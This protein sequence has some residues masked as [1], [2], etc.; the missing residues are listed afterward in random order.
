MNV[1]NRTGSNA[2]LLIPQRLDRIDARCFQRG[3]GPNIT[4]TATE[5]PNATGTDAI[6]T[7]V[8]HSA[9]ARYEPGQKNPRS[10]MSGQERSSHAR[11]TMRALPS[12]CRVALFRFRRVINF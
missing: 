1:S 12:P 5:T 2:Y 4:P 6:V 8:V 11:P 10:P 3:I 7:L 9:A